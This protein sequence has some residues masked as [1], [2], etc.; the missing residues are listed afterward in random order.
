[1]QHDTR[2]TSRS[3]AAVLVVGL[4]GG[5][6]HAAPAPEL[7]TGTTEATAGYY[8]LTWSG[9]SAREPVY[10]VQEA[11]SAEFHSTRTVYRGRNGA[12]VLSGL[13]D[14]ERYYRVRARYGDGEVTPWSE[15]VR[16]RV[17]HHP[18]SRAWTFFGVG[19][20]VFLSTL[21]LIVAGGVRE[22]REEA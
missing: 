5:V 19:A 16:V 11:P 21:G 2:A 18:L 7:G 3:L 4:L 15:P 1:M 10:T 22:R 13:P 20:V 17:D 6:A 14:G 12:T 9:D 8:R